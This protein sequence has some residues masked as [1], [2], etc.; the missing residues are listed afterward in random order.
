MSLDAEVLLYAGRSTLL[1]G[2]SG[3][4]VVDLPKLSVKGHGVWCS[5][6][7]VLCIGQEILHPNALDLEGFALDLVRPEC[8]D[9]ALRWLAW[10]LGL[11]HAVGAGRFFRQRGLWVL[12]TGLEYT[13]RDSWFW[14]PNA[15]SYRVNRG[16]IGHELFPALSGV[17][18]NDTRR[19]HQ[20]VRI[21]ELEVLRMVV[22]HTMEQREKVSRDGGGR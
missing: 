7:G 10:S 12:A 13:S 17:D 2:W 15:E 21:V 8:R 3:P 5:D 18:H 16:V 9:Q 14:Y 1:S 6:E 22:L 4:V 20:G 11:N 19:T